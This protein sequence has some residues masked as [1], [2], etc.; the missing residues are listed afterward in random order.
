MKLQPLLILAFS[1]VLI[2][3]PTAAKEGEGTGAAAFEQL[4]APVADPRRHPHR[5]R[6]A[7]P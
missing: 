4:G 3:T 6:H 2:S 1:L 5:R 7:R